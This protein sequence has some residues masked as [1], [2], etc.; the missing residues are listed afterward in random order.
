MR[1]A[2]L[3]NFRFKFRVLLRIYRY[4]RFSYFN[5]LKLGSKQRNAFVFLAADYGNLGDV[6]ITYAQ[7]KFIEEYSSSNVIE[8]PISKSLEGI[9]FVKRN[10]KKGDLITIAGGGNMCDLYDQIEY[11]RQLVVKFFPDNR[12]ISFP[13]TIDFSSS[14]KGKKALNIAS[15]VYNMHSDIHIFAREKTSFELMNCFFYEA[16]VYMVPDIVLSLKE[17]TQNTDRKGAVICMRTDK[18][19]KLSQKLSDNIINQVA[20]KFKFL[21]Y[22]DTHLNR[23][24]LSLNERNIELKKIWKAFST[25]EIVVTDRLH[26]MIFC[27]ITNTPCIVFENSNHKIRG[28]YEWIKASSNINLVTDCSEHSINNF[29]KEYH[30]ELGKNPSVR[31]SFK[32][33]V[34]LL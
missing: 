1:L 33:L 6:A 30:Y 31:E 19:K 7:T 13:Q 9:W 11:I 4:R 3:F 14:T 10:I 5:G 15:S 23:D 16:N 29:L 25:A 27:Y 21:S 28:S 24:Q 26:G 22:Y 20:N 32:T 12:I 17:Q 18:E 2:S 34:D 8:I